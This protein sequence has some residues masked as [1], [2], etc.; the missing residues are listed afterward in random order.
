MSVPAPQAP[1]QATNQN[2]Y[3][4]W[5]RENMSPTDLSKTEAAIKSIIKSTEPLKNYTSKANG[6]RMWFAFL[7]IEQVAEVEKLEGVSDAVP[8]MQFR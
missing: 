4:I 3:I 6:L 2:E 7:T 1:P 8:V 5:P